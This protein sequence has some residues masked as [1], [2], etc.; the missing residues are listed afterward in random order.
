[1]SLIFLTLQDSLSTILGVIT[2]NREMYIDYR[3]EG[4]N[5]YRRTLSLLLTVWEVLSSNRF[6]SAKDEILTFV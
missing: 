2:G 3:Y 4:F 6:A 5:I 1:M